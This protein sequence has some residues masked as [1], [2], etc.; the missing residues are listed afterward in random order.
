MK[1]NQRIGIPYQDAGLASWDYPNLVLSSK[2]PNG[3]NARVVLVAISQHAGWTTGIAFPGM[4]LLQDKTDLSERSIRNALRKL[5]SAGWLSTKKKKGQ[6]CI[7]SHNEYELCVPQTAQEPADCAVTDRQDMPVGIAQPANNA[8]PTGKIR[9]ANRHHVPLNSSENYILTSK[10]EG[11][12]LSQIGDWRPGEEDRMFCEGK[13]HNPDVLFTKFKFHCESKG[14]EY[15]DW[16]AAFRKW[17]TD[18]RTSPV[19]ASG[20]MAG[21]KSNANVQSPSEP[22]RAFV[23]QHPDIDDFRRLPDNVDLRYKGSETHF[24]ELRKDLYPASHSASPAIDQTPNQSIVSLVKSLS[25]S[26]TLHVRKG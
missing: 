24:Y 11:K 4:K 5:E 25:E 12:A 3:T 1:T 22:L 7:H 6:N 10:R 18:E 26:K 13:G 21:A 9:P 15:V 20:V 8:R 2:G 19:A 17:V 16:S 23:E 14:R